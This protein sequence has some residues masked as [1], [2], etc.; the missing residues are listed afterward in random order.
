MGLEP[1][2]SISINQGENFYCQTFAG[3]WAG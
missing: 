3:L 2:I 1:E